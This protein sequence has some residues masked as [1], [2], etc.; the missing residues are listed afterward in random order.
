M[1]KEC[2]IVALL[3]IKCVAFCLKNKVVILFLTA[4]IQKGK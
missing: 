1:N 4:N 3:F 2:L